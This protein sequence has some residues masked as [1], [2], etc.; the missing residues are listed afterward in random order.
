[1]ARRYRCR[2]PPR[3]SVSNNEITR[4][5]GGDNGFIRILVADVKFIRTTER[6]CALLRLHT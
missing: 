5:S 6:P 1:M 4:E 2:V 3:L